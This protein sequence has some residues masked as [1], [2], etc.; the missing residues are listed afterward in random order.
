MLEKGDAT[1]IYFALPTQLTSDKIYDRMN[2]FLVKIL[3]ESD[4]NRR[5]LLLHSSAWLRDTELGEDGSP[6][7]SWFN[8]AKR[9]LLAPLPWVRLIRP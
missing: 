3:D 6:G 5:S 8:G 4:T 2:Q 7:H 1:G 9:G